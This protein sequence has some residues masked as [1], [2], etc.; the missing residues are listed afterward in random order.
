MLMGMEYAPSMNIYRAKRGKNNTMP[1]V[2]AD[3]LETL[4]VKE[5][6]LRLSKSDDRNIAKIAKDVITSKG[7]KMLKT[8]MRIDPVT[9]KKVP[10]KPKPEN[11]VHVITDK[12][13]ACRAA[14]DKEKMNPSKRLS[15]QNEYKFL[16]HKYW[17]ITGA[18][19]P[20]IY[21]PYD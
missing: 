1:A 2:D 3:T 11:D 13:R 10:K 4:T 17:E 8:E 18:D 21:D 6:M 20:K 14:F 7:N 15:I 5:L 19:A 9:G 12:L 16:S